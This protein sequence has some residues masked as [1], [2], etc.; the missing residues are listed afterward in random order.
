VADAGDVVYG[1]VAQDPL[2]V[3]IQVVS[4][5]RM[6]AVHE[7]MVGQHGA[8]RLTARSGGINDQADILR[9]DGGAPGLQLVVRDLAAACNEA[10]PRGRAATAGT[11]DAF[12]GNT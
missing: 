9:R 3:G 6:R 4:C 7:S 10:V 12:C 8:F 1:E 11:L 5:V 2:A